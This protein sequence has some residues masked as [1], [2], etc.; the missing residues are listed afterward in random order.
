MRIAVFGAGGVGGYFG[1]RLALAGEDVVFIARGAQLQALRTQGL[2]VE[3]P[4]GNFTVAS[5][6]ATNNPAEVGAVDVVLVAVKAWQVPEAALAIQPMVDKETCVVPLQNGL[7]APAQ[8]AAVLGPQHVLGG[9]CVISSTVTGPG[10]IRHLGLEPAVSFGALDQRPSPGAERLRQAFERAEVTA[11]M[12]ADIQV[13]IWEKFMAIRYGPIGAVARAPI[14]VL[15]SI[16][17]TRRMIEQACQETLAVAQA[18]HISLDKNSPARTIAVLDTLPPAL[19]AS[20]QRDIAAGRPSE[21]DALTGAL[22][23]LGVEVGVATPLHAFLYHC[24]LPQELC[25]RGQVS[26][27]S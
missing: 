3:S 27:P 25:A 10:C 11:I 24:L 22:V 18:R 15:R 7:E 17:E 2:R 16:P 13:A 26:V 20:I 8:L 4:L 1:G 14:G 19:T 5:V 21:M 6:Q 12:P 9:S 23:R